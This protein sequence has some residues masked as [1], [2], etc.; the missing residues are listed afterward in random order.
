M[1]D[2]DSVVVHTFSVQIGELHGSIQTNHWGVRMAL[3]PHH[4]FV[5]VFLALDNLGREMP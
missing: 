3:Y 1:Q 4:C 5:L 2:R